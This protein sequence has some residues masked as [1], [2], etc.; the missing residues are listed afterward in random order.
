MSSVV[1]VMKCKCNEINF[2][3]VLYKHIKKITLKADTDYKSK[4]NEILEKQ[5]KM[6]ESEETLQ[7][8]RMNHIQKQD[9]ENV[10]EERVRVL[11]TFVV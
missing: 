7:T 6:K 4:K 1:P 10:F 9:R 11:E 8:E 3:N 5:I 2:M